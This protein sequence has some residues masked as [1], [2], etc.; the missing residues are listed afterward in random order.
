MFVQKLEKITKPKPFTSQFLEKQQKLLNHWN[1]ISTIK[2]NKHLP[3]LHVIILCLS[4]HKK[5]AP[6]EQREMTQSEKPL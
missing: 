4:L 1:E 5:R 3:Y 2:L 6:N